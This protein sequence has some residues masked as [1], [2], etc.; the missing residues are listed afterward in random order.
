VAAAKVAKSRKHTGPMAVSSSRAPIPPT[1]K[2]R[3]AQITAQAVSA[4]SAMLAPTAR[5]EDMVSI[6]RG[7]LAFL[8]ARRTLTV[9]TTTPARLKTP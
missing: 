8:K 4:A 6:R 5:R 9:Q 1:I 3:I 2:T 7:S